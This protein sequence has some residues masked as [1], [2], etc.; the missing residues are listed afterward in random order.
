LEPVIE[1]DER[2]PRQIGGRFRT[3]DGQAVAARDD[4]DAELPLDAVEML[5]ALAEELRQQPVVVELHRHPALPGRRLLA[6][7]RHR[8]GHAEASA[9]ALSS[10]PATLFWPAPTMRTGMRAPSC[11]EAA[12]TWTDCR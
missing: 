7:G 8:R 11:S 1:G 5:I 6:R 3:G 2:R 10:T 4:G 12:S 9:T